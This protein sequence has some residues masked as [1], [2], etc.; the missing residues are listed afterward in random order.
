MKDT[1]EGEVL[2]KCK[3]KEEVK[4]IRTEAEKKLKKNY[5]VK[6]VEQ[7]NPHVKIVYLKIWM[8]IY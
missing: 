6:T 1:R 8:Q 2:I 5:D 7:K 4:K 3:S